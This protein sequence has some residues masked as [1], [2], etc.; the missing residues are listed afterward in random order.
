MPEFLIGHESGPSDQRLGAGES[1]GLL[2]P[3]P[4]PVEHVPIERANQQEQGSIGHPGR[5]GGVCTNQEVHVLVGIEAP[6]IG[7]PARIA[8]D[9][10]P[11]RRGGNIG[12]DFAR[13]IGAGG[14][15]ER[16]R[17]SGRR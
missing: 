9:A 16:H 2:D 1:N 8:R 5:G 14:G 11:P 12:L 6:D 4:G 3:G 15:L 13:P 7:K 17:Q 10:G